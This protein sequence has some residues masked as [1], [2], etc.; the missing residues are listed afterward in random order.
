MRVLSYVCAGVVAAA[1]ALGPARAEVNEV[2]LARQFG[3][4]YLPL[5]L[6]EKHKL[7]EKAA[8]AEKIDLKASWLQISSASITESLLSGSIDVAAGGV[9]PMI[10]LWDRTYG[11][12]GARAVAAVSEVPMVL[13][14]RN[15]TFKSFKDISPKDRIAVPSVG[16]SSMQAITLKMATADWLGMENAGKFDTQTVSMKHPDGVAAMLSGQHE[17]N[18]HFTTPPYS[19]IELNDPAIHKV[20]SSYDVLGGQATLIVITTT[21]KFY[22]DNPKVMKALVTALS[23]A[24]EM[25]NADRKKALDDYIEVTR[26]KLSPEVVKAF[27]ADKEI[28]FDITPRGVFKTAVFMNGIGAIKRKP[29]SWQ[30]LFFPAVQSTNG[31]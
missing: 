13:S 14:S 26:E 7:I 17:V 8:A 1:C 12:F 29:E 23:Q 4:P 18:A 27:L 5:V 25:A 22:N 19:Y 16:L 30:D 28:Y 2:K 31:S 15:P 20:M 3:L 9:G 10:L 6:M 11:N 21:G 24:T